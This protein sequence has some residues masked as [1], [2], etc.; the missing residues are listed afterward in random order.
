MK[1]ETILTIVFCILTA[2]GTFI[3]SYLEG[4]RAGKRSVKIYQK[5]SVVV[6]TLLR[7]NTIPVLVDR[8][9][10]VHKLKVAFIVMR[11]FYFFVA[12]P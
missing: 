4:Y 9:L 5:Q 2:V 11:L 6:L 12:S 7:M 3:P 10:R 1:K 8:M